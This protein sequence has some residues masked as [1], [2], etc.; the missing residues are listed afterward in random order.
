MAALGTSET[1]RK[2]ISYFAE[3]ECTVLLPFMEN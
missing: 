3:V 1:I 2:N